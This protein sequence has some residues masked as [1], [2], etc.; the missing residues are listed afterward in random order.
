GRFRF[1]VFKYQPG[2]VDSLGERFP[3]GLL[4]EIDL[5][6]I[7][8][9]QKHWD[10]TLRNYHFSLTLPNIPTLQNKIILQVTF[11][12]PSGKRYEDLLILERQK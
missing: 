5:S 4:E 8:K 10:R 12:N 9:N 2:T 7:S 3:D 1:E 6:L 11:T